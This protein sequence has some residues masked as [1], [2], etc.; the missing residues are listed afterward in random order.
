MDGACSCIISE[1]C[2]EVWKS[3]TRNQMDC[4]AVILRFE[5]KLIEVEF[6]KMFQWKFKGG[7][8]LFEIFAFDTLRI[9]N[10]ILSNA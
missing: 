9:L 4:N 6:I 1:L 8:H 2:L 5:M 7:M 10:A 3:E